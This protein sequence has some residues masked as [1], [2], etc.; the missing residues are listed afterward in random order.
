VHRPAWIGFHDAR[1]VRRAAKVALA[2]AIA[3]IIAQVLHLQNPW[4]AT[5]AA[6]VAMEVTIRASLKSARNALLGA[7]VGALAGLAMAVVAKEQWWAV[8]VLVLAAFV[9]FGLLRMEAAGRQAALVASV[10][11]LVPERVDMSTGQFAWIRFAETAIGIGVALAVNAFVLPPRANR[12]VRRELAGL[13]DEMTRVYS[14]VISHCTGGAHDPLAIREARH[15]AR[16][17]LQSIDEFWDEAMSEHPPAD[18]LATHWR[19]TARRIWEQCAVMASSVDDVSSTRLVVDA[20]PELAALADLT[21]EALAAVGRSFRGDEGTPAFDGLDDARR[22]LLDRVRDLDGERPV[23]FTQ[24]LRVFGFVNA[25]NLIA[26]RLD[27]AAE[28]TDPTALEPDESL[29]EQDR[30]F[31]PEDDLEQDR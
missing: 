26:E 12:R 19:V 3:T 17:H 9:V 22:A 28:T 18:V 29:P 16:A 13:F 24:T 23:P 6:I 20:R 15:A 1:I 21:D 8:A 10:I 30:R 27:D 11:V 14:L 4:F 7:G 31:D 25:M 2:A 5:L